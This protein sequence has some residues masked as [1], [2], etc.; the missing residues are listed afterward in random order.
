MW[1]LEI[2]RVEAQSLVE[3]FSSIILASSLLQV[4]DDGGCFFLREEIRHFSEHLLREF[5][6]VFVGPVLDLREGEDRGKLFRGQAAV[7]RFSVRFA[8]ASGRGGGF[9][10]SVWCGGRPFTGSILEVEMEANAE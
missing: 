1:L 7:L 8:I 2:R 6:H 3:V 4:L 9:L 10:V 5:A